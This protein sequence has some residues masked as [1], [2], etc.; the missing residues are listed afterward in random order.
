MKCLMEDQI[1]ILFFYIKVQAIPEDAVNDES[2]DEDKIDKDERLP[3]NE[4]VY[5]Y[6][7]LLFG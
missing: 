6:Y 2:E 3:Q 7:K 5:S 1:W 4:K